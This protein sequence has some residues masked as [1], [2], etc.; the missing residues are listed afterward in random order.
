MSAIYYK[1]KKIYNDWRVYSWLQHNQDGFYEFYSVSKKVET[2][3]FYHCMVYL[4]GAEIRIWEGYGY[5]MG[6]FRG[7]FVDITY[8]GIARDDRYR[9]KTMINSHFKKN[10]KQIYMNEEFHTF[11]R[12]CR[13]QAHIRV[14]LGF[15]HLF[16]N[17]VKAHI[18]YA[19]MDKPWMMKGKLPI[20]PIEYE[21]ILEKFLKLET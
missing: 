18:K 11:Q 1:P 20:T 17:N 12:L 8:E 21:E 19:C 6:V 5:Y 7:R 4:D 9:I 2:S 15:T 3:D 13:K 16:D 14:E 10:M